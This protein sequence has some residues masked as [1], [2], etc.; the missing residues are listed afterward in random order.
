VNRPHDIRTCRTNVARDEE[1]TWP[2]CDSKRVRGQDGCPLCKGHMLTVWAACR[3]AAELAENHEPTVATRMDGTVKTVPQPVSKLGWIY[4]LKVDD[5]IKV[6]Y[7]KNLAQR[8][9]QYPPNAFLIWAHR[10]TKADEKVHHSLLHLHLKHGREWFTD[11]DE[12]HD[13]IKTLHSA[14]GGHAYRD[15]RT[16]VPATPPVPVNVRQGARLIR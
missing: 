16:F 13:Y 4:F 11:C 12:V 14:Q 9:G 3:D 1:C 6:G 15:P 2:G 10:G 7:T 8:Q 5:A